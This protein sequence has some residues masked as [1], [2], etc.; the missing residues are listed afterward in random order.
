MSGC[1]VFELWRFACI[2]NSIS[3]NSKIRG[4]LSRLLPNLIHTSER[5]AY[6]CRHQP[7]VQFS[8]GELMVLN[9]KTYYPNDKGEVDE[10]RMQISVTNN[11]KFAFKV[12][13]RVHLVHYSL[14][15]GDSRWD[16]FKK[17]MLVRDRLTHP[18]KVSD[19]E[20]TDE[21]VMRLNRAHDWYS[22][23]LDELLNLS[24]RSLENNVKSKLTR[25][26]SAEFDRAMSI[27]FPSRK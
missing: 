25:E 8:D 19:L 21:E 14:N 3:K 24:I 11:I 15:I 16:D 6:S 23:C 22:E 10:Q 4:F 26:Q 27:M 2:C 17:A 5:I 9:E 13:A 20:V 12:Y 1:Q 7:D 18:K